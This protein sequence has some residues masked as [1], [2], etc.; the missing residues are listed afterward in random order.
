[1]RSIQRRQWAAV[2]LLLCSVAALVWALRQSDHAVRIQGPGALVS[3]ANGEVWVGVDDELWRLS[4]D[5]HW[6]GA[7]PLQALGLPAAPATLNRHPAGG[8]VATVRDDP[9]LYLLDPARATVQRTVQPQWPTQLARHGGRAIHL[10]LHADGRIAIATGG[11][12]AVALFDAQGRWLARTA[13]DLYRFT[14]G[15]WWVGDELWTTDTNRTQLKRLDGHTLALRDTVSLDDGPAARYLGPAR[16]HAGDAGRVALIRLRNGMT[17]GQVTVL[18]GADGPRER[19]LPQAHAFAPVDVDWLGDDVLASDSASHQLLRIDAVSGQARVFGDGPVRERLARGLQARAGHWLAW[20]LGLVAAAGLLL[21]GFVLAWQ[22]QSL[23]RKARHAARPID[24]AYLGTPSLPRR[25]Q[26]RLSVRLLAPW[27]LLLVPLAGLQFVDARALTGLDRSTWRV[28]LVFVALSLVAAMAWLQRRQVRLSE[29]P[30]FEPVFNAQAMRRLDRGLGLREALRPD[31][32]VLET[33]LWFSPTL[34]WL[35]LTDLRLL[36]FVAT[37][38][39]HRLEWAYPRAALGPATYLPRAPSR[40]WRWLGAVVAN[41]RGW[42]QLVLPDGRSLQGRV[43]APTVARRIVGELQ[44]PGARSRSAALPLGAP[45]RAGSGPGPWVAAT[46]SLLVPGLGQWLQRRAAV[47]L[48]LF[49]SWAMFVS[50]VAVPL[51][52]AA[53]TP[54][55][56]VPTLQVLRVLAAWMLVAAVAA[57]DAWR[58]ALRRV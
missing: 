30:E 14:N 26:F 33:L 17:Q 50:F 48:L 6:I 7:Q 11:G 19:P 31:E 41:G 27:L 10:A 34:R 45:P 5:G 35:V 4:A 21:V 18:E 44:D 52:L 49:T 55:Y 29:D 24:L 1:M 37:L 2:V 46:L 23:Q 42:L 53:W 56:E 25:L 3:T 8:V 20:K 12:H 39:D 22:A 36:C 43:V 28:A 32:T 38:K 58:L 57:W 9:T 15:L 13:P 40:W 51:L 16:A 54:R 47:G